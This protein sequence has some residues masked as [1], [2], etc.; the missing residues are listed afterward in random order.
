MLRSLDPRSFVLITALG[1]AGC[2]SSGPET[3]ADLSPVPPEPRPY[4]TP[5][6]KSGGN[7]PTLGRVVDE[8]RRRREVIRQLDSIFKNPNP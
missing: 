1:L 7:Q 6:A 4:K 8:T 2:G 3:G 5:A